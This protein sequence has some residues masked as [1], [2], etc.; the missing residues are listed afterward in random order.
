MSEQSGLHGRKFSDKLLNW[1]SLRISQAFISALLAFILYSLVFLKLRGIVRDRA[2]SPSNTSVHQE[3]NEKY[4][5]R[6][7]RQ[8]LLY[9]ACV[10]FI[11]TS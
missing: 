3:R 2:S 1:F 5:H 9:P 8:M 4:E 11:N 10:R 6:L 7:A